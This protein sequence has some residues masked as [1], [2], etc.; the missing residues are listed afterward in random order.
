MTSSD[1]QNQDFTRSIFTVIGGNLLGNR[2]ARVRPHSHRARCTETSSADSFVAPDF[3][4]R[5]GRTLGF[6][7]DYVFGAVGPMMYVSNTAPFSLHLAD[8]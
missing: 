3:Q 8:D 7:I 5:S 1:F 4:L 6:D 2:I